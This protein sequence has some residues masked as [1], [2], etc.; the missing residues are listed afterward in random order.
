[1][2]LAARA[3]LERLRAELR[4]RNDEV[5]AAL[6]GDFTRLG[7]ADP[8]ARAKSCAACASGST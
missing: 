2:N 4:R 7:G 6:P 1:M 8:A 3:E 5:I